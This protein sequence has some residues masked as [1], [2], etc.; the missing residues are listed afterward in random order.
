[1]TLKRRWRDFLSRFK[2]TD[3]V[4]APIIPET[5]R[6]GTPQQP[7][8]VLPETPIA[9]KPS[10][11]FNRLKEKSRLFSV[12]RKIIRILAFVGLVQSAIWIGITALF[13]PNITSLALYVPIFG[14]ILDYLW[15]TQPKTSPLVTWHILPDIE[16]LEDTKL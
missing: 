9:T 11:V 15:K 10:I 8:V 7:V 14:M 13:A 2:S 3:E 1:M 5:W 12:P 4:I 6:E 16:R